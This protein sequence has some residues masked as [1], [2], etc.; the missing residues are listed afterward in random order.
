[1]QLQRSARVGAVEARR[2]Y[3]YSLLLRQF[4][5]AAAREALLPKP[6]VMPGKVGSPVPSFFPLR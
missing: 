4:S 2:C 6:R 3:S 5:V 1:M